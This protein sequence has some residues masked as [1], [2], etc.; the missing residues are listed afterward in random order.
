MPYIGKGANGFGIRERYRYSASGSQTDFTSTDL[1]SKTLQIDSGSLV[2]VYLNGVLLDTADYN[3]NTANQVT[4]TSGATASD[5]VMI[6]VYDVFS[7]SDAMPKTGG[8]FTSS[9]T[10]TAKST[11]NI[12]SSGN[13]IDFKLGGTTIGNIGVI[14]DRVYLTA[15][16]SHGVYLDASANNFCPSSTT[17]TDA[18]GTIDLGAS[19]ARWKD[20]YFS[21]GIH[22][23]GTGSANE[24]EDYEEGT[25]TAT[26]ISGSG[27]TFSASERNYVKV[28]RLVYV[29][30]ACT[31]SGTSSNRVEISGLP[32]TSSDTSAC[33]IFH[34]GGSL[35]THGA[36]L[37]QSHSG[38]NRL[39]GGK[40]TDM[41][42][43][44]VNGTTMRITV[45]YL[46]TA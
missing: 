21:G 41:T 35:P 26:L 30:I 9:V 17:G 29:N 36:F 15:E 14:S 31:F 37:A 7:L 32:F 28:G 46:A 40:G 22:I 33:T 44:D 11:V 6:V 39:S 19:F 12:A 10:H 43:S 27:I 8:T 34:S 45:T 13:A 16:G 42:Y 1:D 18:D 3:T 4:L 5:E 2:D 24:I 25:W 20:A 38:H 23:G